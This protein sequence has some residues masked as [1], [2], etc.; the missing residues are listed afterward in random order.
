MAVR[1]HNE[2]DPVPTG[3]AAALDITSL[4]IRPAGPVDRQAMERV[5]AHTWDWGDYVPEVWE[6]WLA[7]EAGLVLVGEWAGRVVALS[8]I[9]FH[10]NGQVWLEGM[11]VEPDYRRRGIAGRFLEY[12]IDYAR[13]AGARVVRL[14]TSSSN[15]A[16]HAI[17]ARNGMV[18]VGTYALRSAG[19]RPEGPAPVRLGLDRVAEVH[20]VLRAGP[21][22]HH[23]RGLYSVDWA[24]QELSDRRLEELLAAEQVIGWQAAGETLEAV[25]VLAVD[26]EDGRLWIGLVDG[27]VEGV[28]QLARASRRVAFEIGAEKAAIMLPDL[29]WLM[30]V[31]EAAGYQVGDWEGQL[32]I[33]ELRLAGPAPEG[34]V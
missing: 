13:H 23:G 32:W 4:H 33:F 7:D 9:T 3:A 17:A 10:S 1:D 30:E 22:F 20:A 2:G 11:R 6:D 21:V 34:G 18:R 25:A 12:S 15:Q 24:W 5:C 8:K 28:G 19:A 29:P 27:T 16:V 14:G 31:F 26:A